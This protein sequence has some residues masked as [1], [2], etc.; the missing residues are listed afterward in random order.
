MIDTFPVHKHVQTKIPAAK[1][2]L[3]PTYALT[4]LLGCCANE[5]QLQAETLGWAVTLGRSSEEVVSQ[6]N[7]CAPEASVYLYPCLEA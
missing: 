3:V 2:L 5:P 1:T 6:I 7:D 4:V